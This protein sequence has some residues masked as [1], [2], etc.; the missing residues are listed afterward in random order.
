MRSWE[1]E[2]LLRRPPQEDSRRHRAGHAQKPGHS[3]VRREPLLGQALLENRQTR[4]VARARK[5]SLEWNNSTIIK[6]D[7]AQEVLDLKRQPGQDI[8]GSL[9]ASKGQPAI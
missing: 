8:L 7:V 5:E 4:R 2:S 9:R 3:P 1:D 6:G